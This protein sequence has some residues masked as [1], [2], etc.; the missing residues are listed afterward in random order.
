MILSTS[1]S[2]Q[3]TPTGSITVA[4]P[5]ECTSVCSHDNFSCRLQIARVVERIESQDVRV[6][7]DTIFNDLLRLLECLELSENNLRQVDYAEETFALF[8]LVYDEASMLIEFIQKEA[9]NCAAMDEDLIDTL[10]GIAFAV[11]HDLR[12][13]FESD[14]R[15]ILTK[16]CRRGI[17]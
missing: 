10:D 1:I 7:V 14:Q 3:L 2:N 17:R 8:Q 16:D 12:R 9:L 6:V 4:Q 15:Y 11:N 13:V 5:D